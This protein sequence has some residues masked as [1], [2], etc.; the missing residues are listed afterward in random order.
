MSE[1][2]HYSLSNNNLSA[3]CESVKELD[4]GQSETTQVYKSNSLKDFPES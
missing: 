3:Q 2:L 1:R 4:L